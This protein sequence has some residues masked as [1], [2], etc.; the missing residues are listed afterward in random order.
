MKKSLIQLLFKFILMVLRKKA[1]KHEDIM[2]SSREE[3][4]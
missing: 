2:N 4:Y 1:D 3:K